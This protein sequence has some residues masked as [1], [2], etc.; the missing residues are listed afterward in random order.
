MTDYIAAA[1]DRPKRE[2]SLFL[3]APHAESRCAPRVYTRCCKYIEKE[4]DPM[5][6]ALALILSVVMCV[7]LFAGCGQQN[8][9]NNGGNQDQG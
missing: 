8:D 5:K 1:I 3:H 2:Y 9:A 7:G 4:L 6:K